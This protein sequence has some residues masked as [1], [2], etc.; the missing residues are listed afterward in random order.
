MKNLIA[1]EEA[2]ALVL[3]NVKTTTETELISLDKAIGHVL[4][5]DLYAPIS[6]PPFRQSAMDGYALNYHHGNNF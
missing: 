6:L 5:Q 3:N 2:L 1:V 4:A